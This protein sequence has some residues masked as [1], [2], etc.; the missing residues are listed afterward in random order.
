MTE[1]AT[2][3]YCIVQFT[4]DRRRTEVANIGVLLF[5]PDHHF[6]DVRL[7]SSN[8]RI[9]RFFG[10]P[11]G[12]DEE[13]IRVIRLW[14]KNR[15]RVEAEYIR[16]LEDLQHFVNTRAYHLV[17]TPPRAFIV[18]DPSRDL[19]K[20]FEE[21]VAEPAEEREPW[22]PWDGSAATCST[23]TRATGSSAWHGWRR[24]TGA[25]AMQPCGKAGP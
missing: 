8:R 14:L 5:S 17:L 13:H 19:D 9:H 20:L 4:P 11:R 18:S 7:A 2:G 6:L 22:P 1:R 16:T 23:A 10:T 12:F 15:L 25:A 3:Y 24:S 21:L